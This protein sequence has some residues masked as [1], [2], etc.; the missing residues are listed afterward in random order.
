MIHITWFIS[1]NDIMWIPCQ[2]SREYL[3]RTH[4]FNHYI[5]HLLTICYLCCT[6]LTFIYIVIN[7]R[8]N[9]MDT[10]T[11]C[12]TCTRKVESFCIHI[13][14]DVCKHAYYAKCVDLT[15]EEVE[16]ASLWYY[17]QVYSLYLDEGN[18]FH[19]AVMENLL[20][21]S[22]HYHEMSNKIFIPF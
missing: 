8:H 4:M 1:L 11:L 20:Y 17:S 3:H 18:E 9:G 15:R 21:C 7:V 6:C 5:E 19:S 10:Y 13:T 14:C 16:V 22:Y 12:K 2:N